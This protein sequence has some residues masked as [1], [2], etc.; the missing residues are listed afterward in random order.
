[1][2]T[3]AVSTR[4]SVRRSNGT[5]GGS[6]PIPEISGTEF[7][8]IQRLVLE[9]AGIRLAEGKQTL[10]R[11]RLARR[12][13][14]LGLADLS[15]Y[16]DLVAHAPQEQEHLL[17]ALTT[18]VTAFFR[19]RDHFDQLADE[20]VDWAKA[21]RDPLRIWSCGC[22]MGHEPYSIA[23]TL[24]RA[25]GSTRAVDWR[26]LATDIST[27]ALGLCRAA[28]YPATHL[29]GLREE[30][31]LG[32]QLLPQ[33]RCRVQPALVERVK[34]AWMNIAEVPYPMRG[35][36]DAVFCRN[37]M[38]Y[39]DPVVRWQALHEAGRL[40]RPGG[41]LFVGHSESL[42]G[43]PAGFVTVRPSVYRWTRASRASHAPPA[44]AH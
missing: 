44:P 8:R 25:L 42:A 29:Q 19:E 28:N 23:I 7:A 43:I 24:Q 4:R 33:G 14:T 22:S 5:G 15:A 20:V 10:V 31:R 21:R 6:S 26:I 32:F 41:L 12:L 40:L 11:A 3:L 35:P 2:E 27:R 36:F 16:L 13:R 38:I 30:E 18:N 9:L 1:M 34:V 17:N 39:L 37:V